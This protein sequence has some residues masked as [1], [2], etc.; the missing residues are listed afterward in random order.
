MNSWSSGGTWYTSAKA[1]SE[2]Y[3]Y[4]HTYREI[5]ALSTSIYISMSVNSVLVP[6]PLPLTNYLVGTHKYIS[7]FA[8]GLHK[9]EKCKGSSSDYSLK[10]GESPNLFNVSIFLLIIGGFMTV[11]RIIM[12]YSQIITGS[13]SFDLVACERLWETCNTT[14][15]SCILR[16]TQNSQPLSAA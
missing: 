1:R 7:W 15:S 6:F 8:N 9:H 2:T 14:S 13:W 11:F 5:I 10:A 16:H 12:V 4:H 3:L